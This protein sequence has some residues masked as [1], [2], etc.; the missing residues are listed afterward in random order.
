MSLKLLNS[1]ASLEPTKRNIVSTIG[2]F[3]DPLGFLAPV[4]IHLKVPEAV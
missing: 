2:K 3:Y 4:V 1:L